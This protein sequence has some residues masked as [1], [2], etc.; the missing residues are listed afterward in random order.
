MYI[1]RKVT[2]TLQ[3]YISLRFPMSQK[4]RIN[5]R[6]QATVGIGG[7]VGDVKRRF[8]HLYFAFKRDNRVA[9]LKTSLI[10]KNP[11]F[12]YTEQENF[13]N[14]IMVIETSLNAKQFLAYLMRMEK[15]FGRKRSFANAPRSLD[16]DIVFFDDITMNSKQLILPHPHWYKRQSVVIPLARLPR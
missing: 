8:E 4:S 9:L 3:T 10:L 15:R 2:D 6:H 11:P 5:Y 7:N 16:L 1:K 14:S 12:G 13:F